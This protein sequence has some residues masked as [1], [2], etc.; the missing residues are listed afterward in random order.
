MSIYVFIRS[1]SS[2]YVDPWKPQ[3]EFEN[4]MKALNMK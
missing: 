1:V 2:N 4:F 3:L